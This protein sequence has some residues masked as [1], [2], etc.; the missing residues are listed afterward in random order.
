MAHENIMIN[1][2]NF[3]I[4]PQAGTYCYM[5]KNSDPVTLKVKNEIGSLLRTYT[6]F[7]QDILKPAPYDYDSLDLNEDGY[8]KPEPISIKYVGPKEQSSF[9]NNMIFYT[10]ERRG[11]VYRE[12][13]TYERDP[14]PFGPYKLKD[15][16]DEYSLVT[17]YRP[18]YN[19]NIIRKWVLDDNSQRLFLDKVFYKNSDEDYWFDG[20]A[21]DIN[22]LVTKFDD[23]TTTATGEI[24]VTTTSGLKKYDYIN[25]GPSS[26]TDNIGA[27][28]EVY[29]H[30]VLNNTVFIKTNE[31]YIPPKY[32]Y[33]KDDPITIQKDILLFSNP[34]PLIDDYGIAY[35]YEGSTILDTNTVVSGVV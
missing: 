4:G 21:F 30:E 10:L 14:D 5:D 25:L 24:E 15:S 32:E 8:Y 18:E 29:V 19:S 22:H 6:F 7:P 23:H 31:G 35:S 9:Y 34:R 13:Y 26:D 3:C 33:V 2:S 16:E 28:E 1:N 27:I 20:A 12:Y 17:D 11:Q